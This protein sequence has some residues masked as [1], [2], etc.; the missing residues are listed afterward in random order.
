MNRRKLQYQVS[1][2]GCDI[3]PKWYPASYLWYAPRLVREFHERYPE[4]EGPPV[5]LKYWLEYAE[6]DEEPEFRRGDELPIQ[7]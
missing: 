4:K 6:K 2:K 5:G 7:A 1:W 3:D